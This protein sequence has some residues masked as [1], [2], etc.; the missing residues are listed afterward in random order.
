MIATMCDKK[1]LAELDEESKQLEIE[2]KE[3]ITE[4]KR[5]Y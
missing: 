4:S 5:L 3:V 1:E 2:I